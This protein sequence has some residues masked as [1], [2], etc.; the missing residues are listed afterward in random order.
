MIS[1]IVLAAGMSKRM[2]GTPKALLD[3]GGEPLLRYQVEQLLEAGVD[4]VVV[5]LG[6]RS[7]EIYRTIRDLPCRVMS[8]AR[9]FTG[10]ANSLRIGAKA[11]N[12]DADA[13]VVLNVDQ[14][15]PAELI[16]KLVA[17]HSSERAA[18]V[19]RFDGHRGHP[20]VVAGRLREEMMAADDEH[21]G[22]HGVLER[23]KEAIGEVEMD[24]V[25]GIDVNTPED[26][27]KARQAFGLSN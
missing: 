4:E 12:R 27:E 15:R 25:C 17:A 9:Y 23:Y 5:V 8:N 19:P 6:H 18:T 20:V 10:R 14:P 7:D 16:R 24:A 21:Q 11:V 3:W 22:L 13:I 2:N 26:Y 1:S